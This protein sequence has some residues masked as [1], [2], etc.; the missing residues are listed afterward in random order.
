MAAGGAAAGSGNG[1][2]SG[3]RL[4]VAK[5]RHAVLGERGHYGLAIERRRAA[6]I[7]KNHAGSYRAQAGRGSAAAERRALS[8]DD[9]E[10]SGLC[11]LHARSRGTGDELESWG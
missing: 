5:G 10:R 2:H 9:R 3:R 11:D 1:P 4:A 8:P 6:W 7:S